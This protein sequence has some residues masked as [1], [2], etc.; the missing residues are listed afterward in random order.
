MAKQRSKPKAHSK[1][2]AHQ[3]RVA[4]RG[5]DRQP[6]SASVSASSS[7]TIPPRRSTYFEANQVF[8]P[9]VSVTIIAMALIGGGD[10]ARG[11]LLGVLALSLLSELLWVHAPQIYMIIL[12]AVLV[13]FVLLLPDGILGWQARRRAGGT[14]GAA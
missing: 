3:D 5:T 14:H 6:S 8:D 1:I 11:P 12:G 2:A 10:S 7:S 9:M 13:G 4:P